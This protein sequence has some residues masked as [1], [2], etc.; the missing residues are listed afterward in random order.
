MHA[1]G[2]V[3]L[4]HRQGQEKTGSK[5]NSPDSPSS[6]NYNAKMQY[7]RVHLLTFALMDLLV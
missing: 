5:M 6:E 7:K 4:L 2:P 1:I 3:Q